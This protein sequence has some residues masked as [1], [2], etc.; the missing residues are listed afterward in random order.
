MVGSLLSKLWDGQSHTSS[1]IPLVTCWS[2]CS[3]GGGGVNPPPPL[4]ESGGATPDSENPT[5]NP[6][7]AS[8][9]L[10]AEEAG[11]KPLASLSYHRFGISQVTDTLSF[12]FYLRERQETVAQWERRWAWG[13]I[14]LERVGQDSSTLSAS[15]RRTRPASEL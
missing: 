8:Q 9:G 3:A 7:T 10:G 1:A 11:P 13:S 5:T 12:L 6:T 15:R 4:G 2:Y 14:L